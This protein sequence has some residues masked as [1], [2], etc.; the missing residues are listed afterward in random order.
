M[1]EESKLDP[2]AA[3]GAGFVGGLAVGVV[4][5]LGLVGEPP[6]GLPEV[7]PAASEAV[8]K[9]VPVPVPPPGVIFFTSETAIE[10]AARAIFHRRLD[11]EHRREAERRAA[12]PPPEPAIFR[13]SE[14]PR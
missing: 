6:R 12:E 13:T 14:Q 11:E 3:G 8:S 9:I 2:R 4:S 5:A 1:A 7:A 10:Q